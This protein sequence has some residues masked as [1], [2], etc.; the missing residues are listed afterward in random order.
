RRPGP[1]AAPKGAR[2][3]PPRPRATPRAGAPPDR[4]ATGATAAK[5]K[6]PVQGGGGLRKR[7]KDDKGNI[8][9][10]DYRHGEW[11]M[12]NKLQQAW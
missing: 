2:E 11:E 1:G 10:W 5:R 3:S 4:G 8:Y 9:E 7:W 6:T 12:Y